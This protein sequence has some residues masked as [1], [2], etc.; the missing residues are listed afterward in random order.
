MAKYTGFNVVE[1]RISLEDLVAYDYSFIT[2]TA[3]EIGG[4]G[5]IDLN[6]SWSI[7]LIKK[8]RLGYYNLSS[9]N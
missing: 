5:S 8:G 7:F 1:A 9:Q 6:K 3:R 4:I 2:G